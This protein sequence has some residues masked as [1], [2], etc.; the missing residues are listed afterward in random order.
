[1]IISGES[2]AGKTEAA[3]KFLFYI[4]KVCEE[5]TATHQVKEKILATNPL[6]ESFGN[7]KT[8]RNNNSSRFGKYLELMFDEQNRPVGAST[9]NYLLEKARVVR[10]QRGERNFH[11]FYQ[12]CAGATN[13]MREA[14]GIYQAKDYYYTNQG[15]AV[16][17][18]GTNDYQ[19]F[20]ETLNAMHVFGMSNDEIFIVFRLLASIL[21]MGNLNF[22]DDRDQSYIENTDGI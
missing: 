18:M 16:E 4:T 1:M 5:T 14:F 19:D 2:G 21:W 10:Q 22:L 3:K 9:T 17:L 12:L 13:E 20:Q 6:L 15:N 11:I 7:A 8:I